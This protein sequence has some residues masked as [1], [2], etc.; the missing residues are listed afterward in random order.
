MADI[1]KMV[2]FANSRLANGSSVKNVEE[3]LKEMGLK[4]SEIQAVLKEVKASEKV[5]KMITFTW[6][7]GKEGEEENFQ[8]Y[9]NGK[10]SYYKHGGMTETSGKNFEDRIENGEAT[11]V[12]E[13]TRE[14]LKGVKLKRAEGLSGSMTWD[15]RRKG[16]YTLVN[17]SE[18]ELAVTFDM[19]QFSAMEG[20]L[21]PLRIKVIEKNSRKPLGFL[22]KLFG[23]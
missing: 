15:L 11:Q 4:D 1:A 9:S 10:L 8:L 19:P 20:I 18:V 14:V 23:K 2:S 7:I 3:N 12:F 16:F 21:G 5:V 6:N 22:G 13:K 17:F